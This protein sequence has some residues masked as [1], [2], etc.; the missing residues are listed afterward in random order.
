MC[1]RKRQYVGLGVPVD[2]YRTLT[3]V[4]MFKRPLFGVG[5]EGLA[6]LHGQV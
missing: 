1:P 2:K 6:L 3:R 5:V 4:H